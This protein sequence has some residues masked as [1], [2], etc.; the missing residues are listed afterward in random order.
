MVLKGL[1]LARKGAGAFT[2]AWGPPAR[3]LLAWTALL[4]MVGVQ[5]R[6]DR[7]LESAG[8]G[9]ARR[10][11]SPGV[12]QGCVRAGRRT[13][14]GGWA[15]LGHWVGGAR[16]RERP[17]GQGLTSCALLS[18]RPNVCGSRFHAYCCPGWRTLPGGNQCV[19]RE[20]HCTRRGEAQAGDAGAALRPAGKPSPASQWTWPGASG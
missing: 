9:R 1:C 10:R 20:C 3:L 18:Q 12:L 14:P 16:P 8:P 11:G 13:G 2:M 19:V 4:C 15:G 6:W 7:A 17:A 5:G